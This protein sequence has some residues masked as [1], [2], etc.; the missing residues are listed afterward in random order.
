MKIPGYKF[1]KGYNPTGSSESGREAQDSK[2][3]TPTYRGLHGPTENCRW[4]SGKVDWSSGKTLITV[5]Y[6]Y[7]N[8]YLR[9]SKQVLKSIDWYRL[10]LFGIDGRFS[11]K[12]FYGRIRYYHVKVALAR[13]GL[14]FLNIP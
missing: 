8:R 9:D 14:A 7:V 4:R 13:K 1:L 5:A 6:K 2:Q 12:S 3:T 11:N 10:V